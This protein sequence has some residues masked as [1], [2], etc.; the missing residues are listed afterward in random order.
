MAQ[1]YFKRQ[2]TVGTK[3][4]SLT[5]YLTDREYKL[6]RQLSWNLGQPVAV[7]LEKWIRRFI[8]VPQGLPSLAELRPPTAPP[9]REV[10]RAMQEMENAI[11]TQAAA[12][13]PHVD[14]ALAEGEILP[15]E[16]PPSRRSARIYALNGFAAA[17]RDWASLPPDMPAT[18]ETGESTWTRI[19]LQGEGLENMSPVHPVGLE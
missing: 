2:K 1:K 3:R 17:L 12:I 19:A 6:F 10:E 16:F 11:L 9:P 14:L 15:I 18:I 7:T 5:I 4:R 8:N 13:I